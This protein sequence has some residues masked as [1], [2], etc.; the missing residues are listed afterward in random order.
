MTGLG[1]APFGTA[2]FGGLGEMV[3]RGAVAI[4]THEV[5]VDFDKTP[6]ALDSG[7]YESATNPKNWTIAAVDP[8]RGGAR[9]ATPVPTYAPAVIAVDYDDAQPNQVLVATD[10]P[11][12]AGVSYDVT[13]QPALRGADCETL[14]DERTWRV[15][16]R[17]APRRPT[18]SV[19]YVDRY[20][21]FATSGG[22]LV[23][24]ESGDI[25]T[26]S[27]VDALKIRLFR[28]IA[29]ALGGFVM[30][31]GY[32]VDLRLKELIR[33]GEIQAIANAV[34]AQ[35][36]QEP[37]VE[38]GSA[39][40]SLVDSGGVTIMQVAIAVVRREG[41]DLVFVYDFPYSEAT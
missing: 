1:Q 14:V 11:L 21:D 17:R 38:R 15:A 30:L 25:D 28:R 20:R 35:V 3:I 13:A 6:Q 18:I 4:T 5:L 33:S 8:T 31:T 9:P 12:E 27:D 19:Y 7:G 40:V 2:R 16:A 23:L 32:G 41:A 22:R 34:T 29:T 37:D 36:G 24:T 10:L 39:V 26:A